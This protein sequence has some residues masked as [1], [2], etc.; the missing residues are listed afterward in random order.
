M[1]VYFSVY[2]HTHARCMAI[3]SSALSATYWAY[4]YIY[5]YIYIPDLD[6]KTVCACVCLRVCNSALFIQYTTNA[7][8]IV[9]NSN[10]HMFIT[11]W[12]HVLYI[13]NLTITNGWTWLTDGLTDWLTHTL[14]ITSAVS[15]LYVLLNP[16]PCQGQRVKEQRRLV[17]QHQVI[18][19]PQVWATTHDHNDRI[20]IT[21]HIINNNNNNNC[22]KA[23]LL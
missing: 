13:F 20:T 2:T 19:E 22:Q 11:A 17:Q 21:N 23:V 4:I 1:Y 3:M 8:L 16:P 5:I 6:V 18:H 12:R 7:S 10:P 9:H 15:S 14:R